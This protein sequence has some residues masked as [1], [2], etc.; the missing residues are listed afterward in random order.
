MKLKNALISSCI[1]LASCASNQSTNFL[2]SGSIVLSKT[3]PNSVASQQIAKEKLDFEDMNQLLGYF[4]PTDE[5]S[6][7]FNETWL[8]I[9]SKE[10]KVSLMQGDLPIEQFNFTGI[11]SAKEGAYYVSAKQIDPIWN[12]PASYFINRGL[13]IPSNSSRA[14]AYG[15]M[16]VFAT[17]GLVIHS[18]PVWISEVGGLKVSQKKLSKIFSSLP[19]GSQI[20][21]K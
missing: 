18:A 2:S 17:G 8:E 13:S 7:A 11:I 20:L 12:A 10:G 16:A 15:D 5:F 1:I 3:V 6:P 21:V 19:L 9:N 4:P 14:G